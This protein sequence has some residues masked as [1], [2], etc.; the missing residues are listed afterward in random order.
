M[1]SHNIIIN[2]YRKKDYKGLNN[3]KEETTFTGSLFK[4]MKTN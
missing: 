1:L 4:K 2:N 3:K